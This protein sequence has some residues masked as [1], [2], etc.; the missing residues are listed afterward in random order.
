MSWVLFTATG[1]T[2]CK[3]VKSFMVNKGIPFEEKDMKTDGKEDFK[4]FYSAN[5]GFITRGQDGV[6]FPVLTDGLEIRQ[7][8]GVPDYRCTNHSSR[9]RCT[10]DQLPDPFGNWHYC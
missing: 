7:G 9:R 6:E 5:R 3:I 8:I 10:R 2:R 4:K 1:C